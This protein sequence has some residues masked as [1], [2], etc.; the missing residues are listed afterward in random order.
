MFCFEERERNAM[1]RKPCVWWSG[2]EV[3]QLK[4]G[5]VTSQIPSTRAVAGDLSIR[6]QHE[7]LPC[8]LTRKGK[9]TGQSVEGMCCVRRQLTSCPRRG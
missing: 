9:Q 4:L 1:R 6:H 5:S 3:S 7:G 2:K 8:H